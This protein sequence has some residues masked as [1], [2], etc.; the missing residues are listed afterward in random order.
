MTTPA[1]A[2]SS[3][4]GSERPLSLIAILPGDG[5]GPEVVDAALPILDAVAP[6]WSI[7]FGAIGW[8]CWRSDGEPIPTATWDLI[9][10]SDA[11]LMGAITSKPPREVEAELPPRP[12]VSST[13]AEKAA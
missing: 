6:G 13:V 10:R 7:E 9:E 4:I 8:D 12:M 5:I 3:S 11:T 1:W 2:G